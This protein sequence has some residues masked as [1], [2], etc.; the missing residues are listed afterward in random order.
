MEIKYCIHSLQL[1]DQR[2][3]KF[4]SLTDQTRKNTQSSKRSVCSVKFLSHFSISLFGMEWFLQTDH[5]RKGALR[6]FKI[7]LAKT[8]K[9]TITNDLF[10]NFI[11]LKQEE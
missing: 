5:T 2:L 8:F 11:F 9:R 7:L 1:L 3:D 6:H 4:G 10:F